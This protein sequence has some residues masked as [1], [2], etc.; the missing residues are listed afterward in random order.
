MLPPGGIAGIAGFGS[1]F[2][3]TMASAVTSKPATDAASWSACRTTLVWRFLRSFTSASVAGAT[4]NGGFGA[5]AEAAEDLA[6]V[7]CGSKD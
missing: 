2:S 5:R 7:G 4:A 6:R 3:A 1:G